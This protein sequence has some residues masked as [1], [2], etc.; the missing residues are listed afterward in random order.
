MKA[1]TTLFALALFC[2]TAYG[3]TIK[4]LGYNTTNGQVVAN[5][6]TNVLTFTNGLVSLKGI[7][8]EEV[9]SLLVEAQSGTNATTITSTGI[10]FAG[11]A[12]SN[13]RTSLGLYATNSAAVFAALAL[14]D[15]SNSE[16]GM[17][18]QDRELTISQGLVS[19]NA[20]TDA[21]NAVR[22]I[23]VNQGTNSYRVPLYQ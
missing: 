11:I 5:T 17:A 8:A 22:W 14:W 2:A 4:A 1:L 6:G 3:Q 9:L 20:P 15:D 16:F 18:V 13:T 23:R 21:T 7:I 12:A 10:D 19:T